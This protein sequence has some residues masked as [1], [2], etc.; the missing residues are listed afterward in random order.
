[1]RD[2]KILGGEEM[3]CEKNQDIKCPS[4]EKDSTYEEWYKL[5]GDDFHPCPSC[6]NVITPD[7]I[8]NRLSQ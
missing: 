5:A 6:G 1:M 2:E 8:S 4:C 7:E 3:N